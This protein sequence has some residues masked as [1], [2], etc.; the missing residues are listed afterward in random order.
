MLSFMA[1]VVLQKL[2]RDILSWR[3]KE[4]RI[5]LQGVVMK[6]RNQKCKAY[7]RNIIPQEQSKRSMIF[8]SC[9]A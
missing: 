6:Q 2:Q 8:T 1:K 4:D 3:K 5:N 9:W 7:E